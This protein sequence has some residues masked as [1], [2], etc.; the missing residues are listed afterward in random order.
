VWAAI[1]AASTKP[2]GF[3][4]FTPGPGVGG[5]CLPIDPTYLSWQVRRRL[6]RSFRFVELANDVNDH[7]PNYVVQRLT[8]ALNRRHLAVSE[9]RILALGVAYKRN[10]GDVR[11]S[12]ALRVVEMLTGMGAIVDVVD[13]HVES[14]LCPAGVKTVELTEDSL[15]LA[16]AV[17]LL[18]DHDDLDYGLVERTAGVVLDTRHR[19]TAAHVESL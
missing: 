8:S 19:L 11:E 7:M 4:R 6:R 3:E 1:D 12:P 5:H 14:H 9:S 18:T 10:T 13:S 17:V 16:D 15:R 2:F